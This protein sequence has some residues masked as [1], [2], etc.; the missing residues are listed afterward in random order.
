MVSWLNERDSFLVPP[1]VPIPFP[2]SQE[3]SVCPM[4][5]SARETV[6]QRQLGRFQGL[7]PPISLDL[8]GQGGQ[9]LSRPTVKIRKWKGSS[10]CIVFL[11]G[12]GA[13][14]LQPSHAVLDAL[15]HLAG[16]GQQLGL[17]QSGPASS[18]LSFLEC[19]PGARSSPQ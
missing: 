7:L 17:R 16:L 9:E 2:A 6:A 3:A 13:G 11:L 15:V 4:E 19:W 10:S 12:A 18:L 8:M 5:A 1:S 14:A